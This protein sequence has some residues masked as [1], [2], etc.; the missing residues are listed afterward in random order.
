TEVAHL[1][2]EHLQAHYAFYGDYLGVRTARKHIG[3]YVRDLPGGE[4]FRRSMNRI[5]DC[6]QQLQ[7]VRQFFAEQAVHGDRLQYGLADEVALAA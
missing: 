7:A 3:W 2:D 6:G 1:M 4:T 5:E